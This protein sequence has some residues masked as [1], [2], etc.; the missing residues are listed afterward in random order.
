[1]L[2]KFHYVFSDDE[3]GDGESFTSSI[4][5]AL[6]LMN[7]NVTNDSIR[8]KQ[9]KMLDGI[10]DETHSDR[11][12]LRQIFCATVSRPPSDRELERLAHLARGSV[13][14]AARGIEDLY[15]ALLNSTEFLTNH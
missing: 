3:G 9:S 10:L 12:R 11:E 4:P 5:Q 1:M 2:E 6:Y 13:G 8:V 7:G 14:G 15:W